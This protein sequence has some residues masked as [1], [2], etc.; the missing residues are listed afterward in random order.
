LYVSTVFMDRER[1]FAISVLDL[2]STISC[3]ISRSRLLRL[4]RGLLADIVLTFAYSLQIPFWL[5][6]DSDTVGRTDSIDDPS[7]C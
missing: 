7:C 2:L 6:A 5:I 4:S 1:I 3:K